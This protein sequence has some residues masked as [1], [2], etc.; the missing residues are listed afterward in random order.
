M[1][2]NDQ[3]LGLCLESLIHTVSRIGCLESLVHTASRIEV[4]LIAV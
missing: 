1:V 4:L 3:E 2:A